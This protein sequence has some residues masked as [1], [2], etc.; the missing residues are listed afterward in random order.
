MQ[1]GE[2]QRDSTTRIHVTILPQTPLPTQAGNNIDR[3][4]STLLTGYTPIQNVFGVKK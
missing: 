2:Q 1:G 4:P 3:V